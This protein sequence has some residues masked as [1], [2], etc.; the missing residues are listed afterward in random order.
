M[1]RFEFGGFCKWQAKARVILEL[2]TVEPYEIKW[3]DKVAITV[4]KNP[5]PL[6]HQQARAEYIR[7]C[8]ALVGGRLVLASRRKS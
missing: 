6:L 1:K 3:V 7:P 4:A 8:M 5:P 2:K